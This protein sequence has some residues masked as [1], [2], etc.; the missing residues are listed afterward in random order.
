MDFVFL[1]A[2]ALGIAFMGY[3]VYWGVKV[4][5]LAKKYPHLLLTYFLQK[6]S[7]S[8]LTGTFVEKYMSQSKSEIIIWRNE[9][10]GGFLRTE[11]MTDE[12][13]WKLLMTA[14][15]EIGAR[16]GVQTAIIPR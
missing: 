6:D 15:N 9:H 3:A 16:I 12:D 7:C 5:T 1:F 13:T 4:A 14:A 10:T 2:T 8:K 11:N